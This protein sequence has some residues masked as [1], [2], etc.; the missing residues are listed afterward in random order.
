MGRADGLPSPLGGQRGSVWYPHWGL[1][2]SLGQF[3]G[4]PHHC[5][6]SVR[7][8]PQPLPLLL[9]RVT[10]WWR[11]RGDNRSRSSVLSTELWTEDL[12]G[13]LWDMGDSVPGEAAS[14]HPTG[15]PHRPAQRQGQ[16][17]TQGMSQ[18]MGSRSRLQFEPG[19]GVGVGPGPFCLIC[20]Q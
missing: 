15:G 4:Q 3:C 16:R 17:S 19:P 10:V 6:R 2:P 12:T 5:V 18:D 9:L 14:G 20:F 13:M 7:M 8:S 11:L 1:C